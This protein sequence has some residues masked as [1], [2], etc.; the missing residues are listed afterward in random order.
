MNKI[1]GAAALSLIKNKTGQPARVARFAAFM[2][3]Q[4]AEKPHR[5][6]EDRTMKAREKKA[7]LLI[8]FFVI[9][10]LDRKLSALHGQNTAIRPLIRGA[11]PEEVDR[12][13][14]RLYNERHEKYAASSGSHRRSGRGRR[15]GKGAGVLFGNR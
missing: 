6:R 9:V 2:Y 15:R 14:D 5:K 13:I 11:S 3:N 4:F 8:V 7:V 1:E 12:N 10:F